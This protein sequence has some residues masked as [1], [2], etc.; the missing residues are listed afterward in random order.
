MHL[1]EFLSGPNKR[2]DRRRLRAKNSTRTTDASFLRSFSL[3]FFA[4]AFLFVRGTKSSLFR[5]R[6][7]ERERAHAPPPA[8]SPPPSGFCQPPKVVKYSADVF[9]PSSLH[10]RLSSTQEDGEP[11]LRIRYVNREDDNRTETGESRTRGPLLPFTFS[12]IR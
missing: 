12:S 5:K 10:P 1:A 8:P 2:R 7:R 3:S 4:L 9:H 6:E 11:L